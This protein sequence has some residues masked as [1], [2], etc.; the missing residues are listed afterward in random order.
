[1]KI[2]FSPAIHP[3]LVER[4]Y[5]RTWAESKHAGSMLPK[6]VLSDPDRLEEHGMNA[7]SVNELYLLL[8]MAGEL[9]RLIATSGADARQLIE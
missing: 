9:F 5:C 3:W 8:N 1:M 6:G 7:L 4:Q 2:T